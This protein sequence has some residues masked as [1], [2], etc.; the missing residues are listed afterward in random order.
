ME[1]IDVAKG[2][3]ANR[4]HAVN[5]EYPRDAVYSKISGMIVK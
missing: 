1:L 5:G 4:V 2:V 3:I